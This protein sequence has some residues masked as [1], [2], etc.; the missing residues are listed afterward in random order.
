MSTMEA[1]YVYDVRYA[2]FTGKERDA[3]TGL[4]YFEAR[5]MSSCAS[6]KIQNVDSRGRLYSPMLFLSHSDASRIVEER[7][8]GQVELAAYGRFTCS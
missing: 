3:E 1:A 8:E 2:Q 4:D 5:Y 7:L 6:R